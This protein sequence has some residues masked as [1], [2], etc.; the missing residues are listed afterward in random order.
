MGIEENL[1]TFVCPSCGSH[2]INVRE[3]CSAFVRAERVR[4]V[5]ANVVYAVALKE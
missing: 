5:E 1:W 3:A 4:A 2:H